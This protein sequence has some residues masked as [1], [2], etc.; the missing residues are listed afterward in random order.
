MSATAADERF[1]RLAL[2]LGYR[3]LGR[4]WPNPSVGA[5]LV[6]PEDGRIVATGVTQPGGRPHA[7]RI[8]LARAGEAARGA[9]LYV[10]LEPCSHYGQTPPCAEAVVASGVARVVTALEDADRRVAGRG[11]ALIQDARIALST[12]VLGGEAG[13]DHLGHLTRVRM[14]RPAI[15]AKLARTADGF[16]ARVGGERLMITGSGAN[17]RTHMLREHADAIMVGVS[18][19]LADDPRLDVRLPG[20]EERSP[21][22]VVLDTHLRTPPGSRAVASAADRPT[23]ILCGPDAGREAESRLAA[24]G[25]TV[26]RTAVGRDGRLDLPAASKLLGERGLTRVFCEAGPTLADALAREGL[27]DEVVLYTGPRPLAAPGLSA[28]GPHMS[29]LLGDVLRPVSDEAVG[30]D[31]VQTFE[32]AR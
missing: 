2:A 24:A 22:R 5:V 16:A 19:V 13:R 23:W 29:R 31:R 4:T 11:H 27:L 32:R 15:T 26:L 12:G 1:M 30:A 6:S 8:A 17:S 21:V 10:S 20:M 14:G 18:T 25:A 3:N 28:L 7:E 9:T